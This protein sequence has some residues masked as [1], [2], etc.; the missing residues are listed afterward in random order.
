MAGERRPWLPVG[1]PRDSLRAVALP[2]GER[3][4]SARSERE[5]TTLR[6][7][8]PWTVSPTTVEADVVTQGAPPWWPLWVAGPIVLVATAA[9]LGSSF[10]VAFGPLL[11]VWPAWLALMFY[12][13]AQVAVRRPIGP[14]L[15][16]A[17]VLPCA[18]LALLALFLSGLADE[19]R[20][21]A[22]A[23]ALR[24]AGAAV[25]R[26]ESPSWA[27]LYP[28]ARTGSSDGCALLATAQFMLAEEGFV[29]CPSGGP[30]DYL[31]AVREVDDGLWTYTLD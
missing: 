26:G 17:A 3:P 7:C 21:E 20:S 30:P 16:R 27:G 8:E 5:V 25:L 14:A 6:T 9:W 23:G 11:L 2:V 12:L 22:S 15:A 28:L 1:T 10:F 24:S 19:V 18:G 4:T 31:T 13:A 29:F